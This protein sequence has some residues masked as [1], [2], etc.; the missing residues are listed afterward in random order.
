MYL[1]EKLSF[2]HSK[3]CFMKGEWDL[4]KMKLYTTHFCLFSLHYCVVLPAGLYQKSL[5]EDGS[6]RL[7]NVRLELAGTKSKRYL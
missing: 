3:N 4:W 1:F 6:K 7:Y 2:E 5:R